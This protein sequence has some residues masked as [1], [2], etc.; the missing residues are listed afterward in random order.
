MADE[1]TAAIF[2]VSNRP[3]AFSPPA[4]VEI[5]VCYISNPAPGHARAIMNTVFENSGCVILS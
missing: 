4:F 1:R 3:V 2:E 5:R